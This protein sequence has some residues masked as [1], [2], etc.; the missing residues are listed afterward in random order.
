MGPGANFLLKYRF[1]YHAAS[2]LDPSERRVDRRRGGALL[3]ASAKLM[4]VCRERDAGVGVAHLRGDVA[5][6]GSAADQRRGEV[7]AQLVVG[8][9]GR[10]ALRLDEVVEPGRCCGASAGCLGG[11]RSVQTTKPLPPVARR[12]ST[13]SLRRVFESSTHFSFA[14]ASDPFRPTAS[15]RSGVSW[16]QTWRCG[17]SRSAEPP[18]STSSPLQPERL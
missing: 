1:E 7:V 17:T 5:D 6:V 8:Q 13:S 10:Q 16:R 3:V 14:S 9:R 18:K 12:C 4:R 2:E 15:S 11:A